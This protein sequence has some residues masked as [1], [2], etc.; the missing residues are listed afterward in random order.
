MANYNFL[1]LL[2]PVNKLGKSGFDL[3]QKHVFST[4]P[5][6]CVP[7]MALETVPGDHHEINLSSLNRT[8]AMN[9]PA[10]LRGKFRYDFLFVPY[11]QLWHNFDQF[12]TQRQDK[13][14]SLQKDFN[15]VPVVELSDLLQFIGRMYYYNR[16]NNTSIYSFHKTDDFSR[17]A[18]RLLDMLGYGLFDE[19]FDIIDNDDVSLTNFDSFT[20]LYQN[21]Y[22]NIFRLAAYQHIWYDYYR[23]KF[24]DNEFSQVISGTNVTYDYINMFNFD[25]IYCDT[26]ANSQINVHIPTVDN[27]FA[28]TDSLRIANL[29]TLRHIQWKKDIFT[30]ALPGTQFGSVSSVNFDVSVDTL[31]NYDTSVS[32]NNILF[33]DTYGKLVRG[34]LVEGQPNAVSGIANISLRSP[35]STFNVLAL[36]RAEALQAW[37]QNTLRA[38][39]MTDDSY[40][41]HFGVEPYYYQDNNVRYLG[42]YEAMLQI[43]A[44]NTTATTGQTV[45]GKV[46]DQGATGT[47]V[48]RGETIKFDTNDFGVVICISS[49]LPEAEYSANMLDKANRLHEQFD[50]FTPEYQ[51][52]G[53]E[54]LTAADY[55]INAYIRVP[56]F[57]MGYVNRYAMYKTAVDKV[58]GQFANNLYDTGLTGAHFSRLKGSLIPWVTPRSENMSLPINGATPKRDKNSWYVDSDILDTVLGVSSDATEDTDSLLHNVYFDIKSIRPMTV[59]GLPQF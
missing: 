18:V 21:H 41:A 46:A 25:D 57:V 59:L 56:N 3:S 49:F 8:M 13:H 53:L 48:S 1:N 42:S 55:N 20:S 22:V 27:N 28:N 36:K 15:F 31:S 5:G 45:N 39:N 37:K 24:Y 47:A 4:K 35:S 10:F 29:L 54:T 11:V 43:N 6:Q 23:N 44:V 33:G 2:K 7:C 32:D 19:M 16:T 40:R 14:S 9:T 50:F 34:K 38:G 30:S 52:I 58:H 51:N 26:F 12:I 17:G